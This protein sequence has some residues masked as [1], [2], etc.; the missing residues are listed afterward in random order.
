M[1]RKAEGGGS[2]SENF[3]VTTK[4][5]KGGVWGGLTYFEF[6]GID[7]S[8][9]FTYDGEGG[10]VRGWVVG[11]RG[12]GP[13]TKI[14]LFEVDLQN[15][16]KLSEEKTLWEGELRFYPEGPHLWEKGGWWWLVIAEGGTHEG[17]V[18]NVARSKRM[19]GPYEACP[20]NPVVKRCEYGDEVQCTGHMDF[21]EGPGGQ[22]YGVCLGIRRS[23][24][25]GCRM[26]H[27]RETFLTRVWWPED[28]DGWLR[29]EKV[30]LEVE[31]LKREGGTYAP[32]GEDWLWVRDAERGDFVIE[33]GG[34]ISVKSRE[35]D[36]DQWEKKVGFVGRRQRLMEG[37]SQ[38]VVGEGKG[39]AGLAVYKDEH[40][41]VMLFREEGKVYWKLLNR[42]KDVEE[43]RE[44]GAVEGKVSFRIAY[45]EEKYVFSYKEG[46]EWKEVAKMDTERLSGSDFVGP[47]IGVFATGGQ[48]AE[49][50][51]EE[52][53]IGVE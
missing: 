26:T 34:R 4:D 8:I 27:G 41:F 5:I 46:G 3:W 21:V 1:V 13:G 24:E 9:H 15:G 47:V 11:S 2:R 12:P 38:V 39:Q 17:H 16:K 14:N 29:I 49:I 19:E 44:L 32:Q 22:W 43:V 36:L 52:F 7:P 20:D 23:G 50:E 25:K 42:A 10:G 51:F 45:Q 53:V 37:Y 30:G 18:V 28:G 33:D 48:G 40:R 35:G 6:E 31:G